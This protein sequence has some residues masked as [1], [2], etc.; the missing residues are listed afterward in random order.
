MGE[1]V[2][3]WSAQ[4]YDALHCQFRGLGMG[5]KH[6]KNIYHMGGNIHRHKQFHGLNYRLRFGF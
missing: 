6:I 5:E 2:D 4:G 1:M 3:E